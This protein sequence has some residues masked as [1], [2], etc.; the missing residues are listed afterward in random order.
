M[1]V[2]GIESNED[3]FGNSG[4]SQSYMKMLQYKQQILVTFLSTISL[5]HVTMS[6]LFCDKLIT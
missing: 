3:I 4:L 2:K 5:F 6:K 1:I